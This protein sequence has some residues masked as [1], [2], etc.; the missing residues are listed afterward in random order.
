[1]KVKYNSSVHTPA[2]FRSVVIEAKAETISLKRLK[3]VEVL[4]IDGEEVKNNMSR[5]SANRQKYYGTGVALRK[6]GK[7]KNLSA[8]VIVE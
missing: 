7:T 3:I 5:T 2:G 1:M 4:H 6:V 8:C